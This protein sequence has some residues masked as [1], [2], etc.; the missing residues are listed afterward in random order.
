MGEGGSW[1][2][3]GGWQTNYTPPPS[4]IVENVRF[5]LPYRFVMNFVPVV[6]APCGRGSAGLWRS[7]ACR[8]GR[9]ERAGGLH[10]AIAIS[11]APDASMALGGAPGPTVTPC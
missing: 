11:A 4:I 9:R 1:K 2:K 10:H 5:V 7:Q 6:Q 3:E 8:A